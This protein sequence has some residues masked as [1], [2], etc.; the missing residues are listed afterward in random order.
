MKI[1]GDDALQGLCGM[2]AKSC[3][4][5]NI[6]DFLGLKVNLRPMDIKFT[7]LDEK[8]I[9]VE[10]EITYFVDNKELKKTK[11]FDIK[12]ILPEYHACN[13]SFQY[14]DLEYGAKCSCKVNLN[15]LTQ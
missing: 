2:S 13:E 1:Y 6:G 12:P 7:L 14:G 9:K 10:R 4:G 15:K 5:Q 3:N 8:Q 11:Q